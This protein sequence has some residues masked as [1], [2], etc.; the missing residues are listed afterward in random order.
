M[1][2]LKLEEVLWLEGQDLVNCVAVVDF[3]QSYSEQ[4]R[5]PVDRDDCTREV[6]DADGVS[7]GPGLERGEED[8]EL[9]GIDLELLD[10]FVDTRCVVYID[11]VLLWRQSLQLCSCR[12]RDTDS[13]NVLI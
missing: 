2:F 12:S 1:H 3:K 10:H 11:S 6:F 5:K 9:P 8:L 13:S 7:D 4:L